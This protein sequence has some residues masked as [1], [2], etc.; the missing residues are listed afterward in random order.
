MAKRDRALVSVF[1][2][3]DNFAINRIRLK[4]LLR[5]MIARDA[6]LPWTGQ[7]SVNLLDDEE[8]V[9]LI[10]RSGGRFI[11]MGLESVDPVSLK[12]AHKAFNKPADYGR[13]LER[14]ARHDIYAITSFIVGLDGD[15]PGTAARLEAEIAKWPPVLPVFGLLTPY[16]ATPLYDKLKASGRLLRPTHWLGSGSFKAT[17]E[18]EGFTTESFEAETPRGVGALLSAPDV[19]ANAAVAGG[20]RQGHGPADHLPGVPAAVPRHLLPDGHAVGMGEAARR[21]PADHRERGGAR[22]VSDW[23]AAGRR[24]R[25][26]RRPRRRARSARSESDS[27]AA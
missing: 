10:H 8:L 15:R 9:D 20:T 24:G 14:M 11:F 22:A 18:P 3:D 27:A 25:R 4:S 23:P 26:R 17:F 5:E 1:F 6:C 13:I 2:V 7:I 12:S 16:P 21:E 19:R